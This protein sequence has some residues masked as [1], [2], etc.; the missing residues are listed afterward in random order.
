MDPLWKGVSVFLG[1]VTD[2]LYPVAATLI[3]V[4]GAE[5]ANAWAPSLCMGRY[6]TRQRF[7]AALRQALMAAGIE[8][9]EY[10]AT[11]SG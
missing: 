3:E 6:L 5:G 9:N 10:A 4:H 7:V 1:R 11:V 8:G 2:E